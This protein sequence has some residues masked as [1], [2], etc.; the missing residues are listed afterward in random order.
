M[1]LN[2][3]PVSIVL[4]DSG[5]VNPAL[6]S[7]TG[8]TGPALI[9]QFLSVVITLLLV[10]GVFACFLFI[11]IGA[12]RWISGGNDKVKLEEARNTIF[13][14]VVALLILFALFAVMRLIGDLFGLNFLN[15]PIPTLSGGGS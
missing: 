7:M 5:I 11:I 9:S 15:L 4:A 1:I 2:L 3:M 8:Q 12:Y 13:Q 14:A 10:I 6:P